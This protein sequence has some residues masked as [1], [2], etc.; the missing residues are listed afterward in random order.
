MSA[1]SV[2]AAVAVV[3]F[4]A[5]HLGSR[6]LE[7]LPK[8][9]LSLVMSLAGGVSAAYVFLHL[10]PDLARRGEAFPAPV[11]GIDIYLLSLIGL[12]GFFGMERLVVRSEDRAE[13]ASGEREVGPF[14]FWLHIGAFAFNSFIIGYLLVDERE[15]GLS[16]QALY[17]IALGLHFMTNDHALRLRHA[18]LHRR[19][20]RWVLAIAVILGWVAGFV[21]IFH[22]QVVA[23]L[24]A[25]LAGGITFNVLKEELP[26]AEG[27]SFEAFAA[28]ALSYAIMLAVISAV[29]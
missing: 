10:I 11:P 28:G 21:G 15:G 18:A 16:Y 1:D 13:A 22:E 7:R 14:L 24:F 19:H 12:I 3:L 26:S 20:G 25:I 4:F 5:I 6:S 27:G 17:A 23:G 29:S 9:T 8:S 2:F